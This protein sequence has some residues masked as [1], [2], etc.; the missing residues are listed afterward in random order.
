MSVRY[1]YILSNYVLHWKHL[2]RRYCPVSSVSVKLKK[3]SAW[4]LECIY[5]CSDMT[6]NLDCNWCSRFVCTGCTSSN[7]DHIEPHLLPTTAVTA[8]KSSWATSWSTLAATSVPWWWI[9]EC[10]HKGLALNDGTCT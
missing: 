9:E 3:Y 2:V 7:S 5:I 6:E 10:P 1:V 4:V 8:R